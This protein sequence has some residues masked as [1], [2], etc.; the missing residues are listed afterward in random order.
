L[1]SNSEIR[2][3]FSIIND[4][5]EIVEGCLAQEAV[6]ELRLAVAQLPARH[7]GGARNLLRDSG[8]IAALA[9]SVSLKAL[10][11][12]ALGADAFPVRGLYFDKLPDANWN[13]PWHQDTAIALAER[14]ETPGF[15]GWS[16]KDGVT[17]VHPPTGILEQ[18]VALRIHL[19]DCG[20]ENGPLRV[21]PG[22]HRDG[23][24]DDAALDYWRQT[25]AEVS[26]CAAS[27]DVLL[28]KPLL[29]HA[30]SPAKSP[31]RRRV[32]HL[33]YACETLPN[34]LKWFEQADPS[35]IPSAQE[36]QPLT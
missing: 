35:L 24:L 17:H 30:S 7:R 31:S 2:V 13:V 18:M 14:V 26:C 28:M 9:S 4:G 25:T 22:S 12:A 15:I 34:G 19:D 20:P 11:D 5:F 16:V 3:N 1:A 6:E 8:T 10:A 23:K 32:I 36:L 29:L 27:G 21:L 33:E